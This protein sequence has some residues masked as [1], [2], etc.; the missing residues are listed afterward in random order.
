M[1]QKVILGSLDRLTLS[2]H[3]SS[4]MLQADDCCLVTDA[5]ARP[6]LEHFSSVGRGPIE[7][8]IQL[9]LESGTLPTD[10]LRQPDVSDSRWRHFYLVYETKAQCESPFNCALEILL[11][12]YLV[13]QDVRSSTH[14]QQFHRHKFCYSWNTLWNC[15]PPALWAQ[16]LSY[17]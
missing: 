8:S 10:L 12:I 17:R 9:D 7:P 1:S 6:R 16:D 3:A 14:T 13:W 15:L 4:Y 11:L 5:R 2:G